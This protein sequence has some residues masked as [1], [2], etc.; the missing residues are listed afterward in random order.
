MFVS[1]FLLCHQLA[2]LFLLCMHHGFLDLFV[3]AEVALGNV[4]VSLVT[5]LARGATNSLQKSFPVLNVVAL[6]K[7]ISICQLGYIFITRTYMCIHRNVVRG[8]I[9]CIQ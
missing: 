7:S 5:Y 4:S 2:F 6:P 9:I 1:D 8:G 3:H